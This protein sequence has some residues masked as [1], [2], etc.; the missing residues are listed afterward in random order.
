MSQD[1]HRYIPVYMFPINSCGS[2]LRVMRPRIVT[3][4]GTTHLPEAAKLQ[5]A[6]AAKEQ[7]KIFV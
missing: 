3:P 4:S 7:M 2:F 6:S 1:M 5:F